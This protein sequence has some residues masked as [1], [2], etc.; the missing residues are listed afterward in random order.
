MQGKTI[1]PNS[2]EEIDYI[3]EYKSGRISIRDTGNYTF[4]TGRFFNSYEEFLEYAKRICTATR[5][6]VTEEQ[7]DIDYEYAINRDKIY[8]LDTPEYGEEY[9]LEDCKEPGKIYSVKDDIIDFLEANDID[10]DD[11]MID[12]LTME[13]IYAMLDGTYGEE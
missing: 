6:L 3:I 12:N 13:D 11:D 1:Y 10:Y 8:I 2:G 7:F 4:F 5:E 9:S